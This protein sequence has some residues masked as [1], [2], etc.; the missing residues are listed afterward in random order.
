MASVEGFRS[1]QIVNRIALR[2]EEI[3]LNNIEFDA[4]KVGREI[5]QQRLDQEEAAAAKS[6][7]IK[8][9]AAADDKARE[10]KAAE[11]E[12]IRKEALDGKLSA[13]DEENYLAG[14]ET[15]AERAQAQLELDEAKDLADLDKLEATEAQKQAVRDKYAGLQIKLDKD[16]KANAD[17][18]AKETKNREDTANQNSIDGIVELAGEGS[19]IAKG[20]ALTQTGIATYKGAQSAFADTPGGV[21]IKSIAAGIAVATGLK[22]M[23]KIAGIKTIG[24]KSA[25]TAPSITAPTV[26][27]APAFD[28][29]ASL[30]AASSGQV[31]N[32]Q[33]E[34]N[35]QNQVVRAY[36]VSSE[37]TDQ[38][39][40]DS[41]INE[42][43][44]L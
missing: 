12:A 21:V 8:D 27:N 40:A 35:E 16:V 31:Q 17:A 24:S 37:V 33:L 2:K 10:D 44:R 4:A 14:L 42:L 25:G 6:K 39:E 9:K 38:Q 20:V 13:L 5:V 32:N 23:A 30:D 26:P 41:R 3:E 36:V 22:S 7:E 11:Q 15:D 1:E 18:I 28:P 43:A 34:L 29:T 19:A